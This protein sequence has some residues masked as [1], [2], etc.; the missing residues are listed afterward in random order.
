M[1]KPNS[2]SRTA[3]VVLQAAAARVDHF[4]VGP[5]HLPTAAKRAVVQSLLKVGMLE[6]VAADD[7]AAAWRATEN[8]ERLALRATDAGLA[9]AGAGGTSVGQV[10]QGKRKAIRRPSSSA[11]RPR[12]KARSPRAG[13]SHSRL[14]SL[15]GLVCV[16][17]LRPLSPPGTTLT[18]AAPICPAPSTHSGPF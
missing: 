2:L 15:P 4:A 14:P 12:R 13:P 8:G 3:Q 5:E 7:E 11:S 9:A 10:K 1:P 17:L 18:R 16:P 6:E